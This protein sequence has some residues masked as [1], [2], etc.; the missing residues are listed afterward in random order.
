[1][2]AT[3]VPTVAASLRAGMHTETR[4][5]ALASA[6]WDGSNR[7]WE[8]RR[9]PGSGEG[10]ATTRSSPLGCWPMVAP[11]YSAGVFGGPRRRSRPRH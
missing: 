3:M 4:R 7:V 1:M 6:N 9:A 2:A 8:Y 10:S 11:L 5:S